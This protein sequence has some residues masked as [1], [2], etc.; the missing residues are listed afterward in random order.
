M[1]GGTG[2]GEG[3]ADELFM[4]ALTLWSVC[5]SEELMV[6]FCLAV[7]TLT[8]TGLWGSLVTPGAGTRGDTKPFGVV[9][10]VAFGDNPAA[11]DFWTAA[12]LSKWVV[13][14]ENALLY[15]KGLVHCIDV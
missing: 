11:I 12:H 5:K 14:R 7:A 10:F 3:V 9:T 6:M 2:T 13:A 1:V 15:P 4:N 8:V